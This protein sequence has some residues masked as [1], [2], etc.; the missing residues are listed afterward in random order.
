M[1][2]QLILFGTFLLFLL[3]LGVCSFSNLINGKGN[4]E[5]HAILIIVVMVIGL[6]ISIA[7]GIYLIPSVVGDND[8][9]L[10]FW[11]SYL[12]SVVGVFGA[13]LF[14]YL[15]TKSQLKEQKRNDFVIQVQLRSLDSMKEFLELTSEYLGSLFEFN[16]FIEKMEPN[17]NMNIF[18]RL[19]SN[20]NIEYS[21]FMKEYFKYEFILRK[22][23]I[24]WKKH[25]ENLSLYKTDSDINLV[26]FTLS[27]VDKQHLISARSAAVQLQAEIR[28]LYED[29]D[30]SYRAKIKEFSE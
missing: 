30:V 24:E 17:T 25:K 20:Y 19:N 11:G 12:G 14:A 13:A 3:V 8:S 26:T 5:R 6:P 22:E 21:N 1:I 28:E 23:D 2:N 16:E 15:N 18:T 29:V 4:I 9:W 10:D 27:S 7:I